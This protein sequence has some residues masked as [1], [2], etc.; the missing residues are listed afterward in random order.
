MIEAIATLHS[1]GRFLWSWERSQLCI[2]KAIPVGLEAIATLPYRYKKRPTRNSRSLKLIIVG[3]EI[4]P[5]GMSRIVRPLIPHNE[6]NVLLR[7]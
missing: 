3:I 1:R 7:Q 2:Q 4:K 6:E 5:D